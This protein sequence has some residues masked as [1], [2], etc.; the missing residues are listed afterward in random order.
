MKSINVISKLIL[1][2]IF[3]LVSVPSCTNLDEELYD[4]VTPE[5][6]L[7]GEEQYIAYLGAAYT[8]LYGY[9]AGN[10]I[11]HMQVATSDEGMYPTRGSD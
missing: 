4:V 5:D 7:K 9:A 11:W 10:S 8:K 6:F 2:G 3:T 1:I